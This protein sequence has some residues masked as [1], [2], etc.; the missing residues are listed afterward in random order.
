MK[1]MMIVRLNAESEAGR[2]YEAGMP[3]DAKLEAAMGQL[4]E[5]LLKT[6]A[7]VDTAGLLPV[8]KGARIQAAE[9][10]LVVTDGP[11]VE[12]KEVIG[13]YA[14]LRA[15][16]KAEAVEMGRDFMQL[17]LDV[18]GPSYDGELEIRQM[19]DPEDLAAGE[20]HE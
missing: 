20:P 10:K 12:C 6:G 9:N 1:Y 4:I 17:H 13:G 2:K 15:K 14:I 5:K 8:A 3:P 18:L 7:L 16:S 19:F 11:F